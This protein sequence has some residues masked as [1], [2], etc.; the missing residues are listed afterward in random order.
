MDHYVNGPK[1]T[2]YI[3]IYSTIFISTLHVSKD[4]VVHHQEFIIVYCITQLC[5]ILQICPV[6]FVLLLGLV[7]TVRTKQLDTFARLYRDVFRPNSKTK[8]AGHIFTIIQ[9]CIQS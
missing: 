9:S 8:A 6:D 7:L 4:R 2:F 1:C 5:T 3:F